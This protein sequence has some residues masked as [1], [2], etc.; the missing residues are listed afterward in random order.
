MRDILDLHTH[1]L[2]SGHAY[3]TINEMAKEAANK[4]I[5]L[6]GITEHAPLI[7]GTCHRF[8][9][10]NL[11]VVPR[12]M[13]GV[14]LLLGSEVNICSLDGALDLEDRVLQKLDLCIASVHPPCLTAGSKDENT[15]AV[16]QAMKNH[17]R[18]F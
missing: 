16:I 1:T 12:E 8:Y 6:L 7:P 4:E 9:F 14:S 10:E 13:F 3:S 5:E 15:H 17:K 18:S 2:A 11:H